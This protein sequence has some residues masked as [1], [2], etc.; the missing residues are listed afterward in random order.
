M[1]LDIDSIET[2]RQKRK[3]LGSRTI[4]ALPAL[5]MPVIILGGIYGGIFTATEAAAVS[6]AYAIPVGFWIYK[7]FK[8]GDFFKL[9]REAAT[10]SGALMTMILFCLIL[11][12]TYVILKVPKALVE[13]CLV[14]RTIS[15]YF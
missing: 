14:S 9:C 3:E 13:L 10:S 8:K 6:A 1:P 2:V 4:N 12:Q 11:S 7:G 15:S 5:L